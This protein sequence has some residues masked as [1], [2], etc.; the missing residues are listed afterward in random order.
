MSEPMRAINVDWRKLRRSILLIWAAFSAGAAAAVV[1]RT[2]G[3]VHP[4][5]ESTQATRADAFTGRVVNIADGD[6]LTVLNARSQQQVKVRLLG[7][8]APR[9]V[10][11]FGNASRT[12][13]SGLTFSRDVRVEGTRRDGDRIVGKVVVLANP[14]CQGPG[15]PGEDAGLQQ[16]RTGMAR[17]QREDAS[18]QSPGDREAYQQAEF[19]AQIRRL[20]L[21]SESRAA[22]PRR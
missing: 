12:A 20:G 17:W 21:W 6:T 10:R 13:L 2:T 14:G 9:R 1:D 19:Q 3:S 7:V 8:D 5:I 16:L 18:A 11:S 4:R 15:C 22:S